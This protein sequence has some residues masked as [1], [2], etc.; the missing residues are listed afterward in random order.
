MMQ[1]IIEKGQQLGF[2]GGDDNLND[3][4]PQRFIFDY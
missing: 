2:F 4:G 3:N 1:A